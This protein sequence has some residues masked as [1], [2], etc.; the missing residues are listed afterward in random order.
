M[1]W[2]KI[3]AIVAGI[4]LVVVFVWKLKSNKETAT[5]RIYHYDKE[6]AVQVKVQIAEKQKVVKESDFTG[7]FQA[8]RESKI[9][10]E[11]QGKINQIYVDAGDFVRK[12][13]VLVQLDN[14]LLKLQLQTV[15]IQIEGLEADVKRY[16]VLTKSDAIQGVQLEKATLG[17]RTAVIKKETLQEQINKSIVKAPF[18]GIITMKFTEVGAFA[19]PGVPLVEITDLSILKFTINI[20]ENDLK[21]FEIGKKYKVSADSYSEHKLLGAATLIGSK[22]DRGGSYPV[23]F[24]VENLSDTQIKAGMFGKVFLADELADYGFLIPSA[25]IIGTTNQPQ[26]YL[27]KKGKAQLTNI[28]S[29]QK[30]KNKTLVINGLQVGDTVIVNGLINLFDGANVKR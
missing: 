6:A 4:A 11:T 12:G 23:Q 5:D 24:T 29:S 7:V 19:A 16:T 15:N 9:S 10:A 20:S 13:Q 14:S 27:L 28:K 1:N 3:I 21:H 2:K 17:L 26:I 22:A 25:A 30:I 18:D 8:N